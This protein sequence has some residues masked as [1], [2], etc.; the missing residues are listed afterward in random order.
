MFHNSRCAALCRVVDKMTSLRQLMKD[1]GEPSVKPHLD[2]LCNLLQKLLQYQPQQ[3]I[4]AQ[5][6]LQHDFFHT[7]HDIVDLTDS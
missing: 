3:R 4:T 5:Q 7:T 2:A 6:A 1:S